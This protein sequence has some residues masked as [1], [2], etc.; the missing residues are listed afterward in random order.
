MPIEDF[1]VDF[2]SKNTDQE[3]DQAKIDSIVDH[4]DGDNASMMKDLYEKYDTGNIDN[5]KFLEIKE[6]YSIDLPKQDPSVKD[7]SNPD[8]DYTTIIND[9]KNSFDQGEFKMAEREAYDAYKETGE[10]D[11]T[12]LPKEEVE[13]ARKYKYNEIGGEYYVDN[14]KLSRVE[15]KDKLYDGDFISDLQEGKV[16]IKIKDDERL[17]ELA[18]KQLESGS[19][20]GD[21]WEGLQA[22][23]LS[24]GKSIISAPSFIED[25]F[26]EVTGVENVF[27]EFER[28]KRDEMV[29]MMAKDIDKLHD[30][31][32]AYKN[33][34]RGSIGE[35]LTTGNINGL[36]DAGNIGFNTVV[37]SAPIMVA[38]TAAAIASG[39][40]SVVAQGLAS[41]G[42]MSALLIPGEY[43]ESVFS[44]D[45][46]I[47]NLSRKE[48]L[49]RGF[50][51]GLSEGV[52]EGVMGPAGARAFGLFKSGL[53]S[54][55]K[56]A[57]KQGGKK[58]GEVVA[59]EMANKTAVD[60]LKTFGI[61][62]GKEGFTEALTSLSQDLTDDILGVQDLT[63]SEYMS[64]A[65]EAGALGIF[66]GGVIQASGGTVR[67]TF[68]LLPL[69]N[70]KSIPRLV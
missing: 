63:I 18:K 59:K 64:R 60:V 25:V 15:L 51:R 66:M 55:A 67:K 61:D 34:F 41:A 23:G 22:A 52:F 4:Y 16:D 47:Q 58:A 65:S 35:F 21:K 17:E 27:G 3:I 39:G 7:V 62:S 26:A 29:K 10:I 49:A 46:K 6:Y 70:E 19:Q 9:K 43:T 33:D 68:D 20:L 48:K 53:K 2:Y 5:N 54:T 13:S 42:V 11:L 57:A 14:V 12:L 40:S 8:F 56:A 32:R 45:E 44:E 69:R 24:L 1:L 30:D 38:S 31:Q 50:F 28:K 36:L 37:E